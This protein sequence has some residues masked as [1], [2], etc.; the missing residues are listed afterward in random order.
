MSETCEYQIECS[1]THM[2]VCRD[3]LSEF[4]WSVPG[5]DEENTAV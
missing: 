2:S 5:M 1:L 4:E 3:Y